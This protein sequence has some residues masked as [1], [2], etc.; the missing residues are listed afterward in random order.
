MTTLI[1]L[2]DNNKASF[3]TDSLACHEKEIDDTEL[4]PWAFVSK[5]FILPK[6]KSI[7]T[8]KLQLAWAALHYISEWRS[9]GGDLEAIKEI[10]FGGMIGRYYRNNGSYASGSLFF[11]GYSNLTNGFNWFEIIFDEEGGFKIEQPDVGMWIATPTI[12]DWKDFCYDCDSFD[13]IALKTMLEQKLQDESKPFCDQIGIGGDI[14]AT[15]IH[16]EKDNTVIFIVRT[17]FEFQDKEIS[18]LK[19]PL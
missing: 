1:C 11:C 3:Y 7:L 17:I 18:F 15:E 6:F 5:T 2:T 14:H 4:R 12:D 13:Q 16:L 10:P 8:G 19:M 9:I